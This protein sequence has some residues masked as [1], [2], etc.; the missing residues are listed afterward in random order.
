MITSIAPGKHLKKLQPLPLLSLMQLNCG[1]L[2]EHGLMHLSQKNLLIHYIL[3]HGCSRII[4]PI[5]PS[6]PSVP[7]TLIQ[8]MQIILEAKLVSQLMLLIPD[9]SSTLALLPRSFF[10]K[11]K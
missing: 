8:S 6:S 7:R 3:C 2:Y 9:T 10:S 5:P 1:T 4:I 11:Y